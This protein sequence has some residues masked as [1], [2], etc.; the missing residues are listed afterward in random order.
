VR[1]FI[2]CIPSDIFRVIISRRT[3][4]VRHIARMWDMRNAYMILVE[5]PEDKRPLEDLG[6]DG[7]IILYKRNRVRGCGMDSSETG[8]G[9]VAGPSTR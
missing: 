7:R 8:K 3:R 2:I 4:W 6:V 9:P 1:S 5:I